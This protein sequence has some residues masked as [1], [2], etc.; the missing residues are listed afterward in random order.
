MLKE[1]KT[2]LSEKSVFI[3]PDS[4][5]DIYILA[6]ESSCDETACAIVKNGRTVISNVVASQDTSAVRW[7][8]TGNCSQRAP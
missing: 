1:F 3:G 4:K 6:L 7:G 5:E 2:P 8:G